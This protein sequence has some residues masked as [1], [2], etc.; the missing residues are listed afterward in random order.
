MR[1]WFDGVTGAL[2][3]AAAIAI[4]WP[5]ATSHAGQGPPPAQFPAYRASRAADGHP[6]L[7]GIW[8]AFTTANWDIQDHEAQAGPHPEL[9]GAYSAEP[10]GQG[11]VVGNDIPYQPW[12]LAKKKENFEKRLVADLSKDDKWH[13]TGDPEF[14]CYMPGV[15][16][17]NYMP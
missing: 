14:K 15:P 13:D 7:N 6:D 17:A 2:G 9:L 3:T 11:I 5:A 12:A 4:L 1:D 8:Q 16:R 10:A